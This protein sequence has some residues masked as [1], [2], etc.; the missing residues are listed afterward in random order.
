MVQC[1]FPIRNVLSESSF[2]IASGVRKDISETSSSNS[3]VIFKTIGS[4]VEV[5]TKVKAFAVLGAKV[6]KPPA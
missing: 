1:F 4:N 6:L 5:P 3:F 2:V